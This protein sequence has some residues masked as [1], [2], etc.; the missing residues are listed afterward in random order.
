MG[1]GPSVLRELKK[2]VFV[3]QPL[4]DGS[5]RMREDPIFR[6]SFTNYIK[7][8]D[9]L[10]K[11]ATFNLGFQ[12]KLPNIVGKYSHAIYDYSV[13]AQL[14]SELKMH[15]ANAI[16][17]EQSSTM[18]GSMSQSQTISNASEKSG[19]RFTE[20]YFDIEDFSKFSREQLITIVFSILF[21]IYMASPA[22]QRFLTHGIERGRLLSAEE[23][24]ISNDVGDNSTRVGPSPLIKRAQDILLGCAAYFDECVIDRHLLAPEWTTT[25]IEALDGHPF[26]ITVTEA[27]TPPKHIVFANRAFIHQTGYTMAELSSASMDLFNGPDTEQPQLAMYRDAVNNNKAVKVGIV[28]YTKG[29]RHYVDLMAVRPVGCYSVAVHFVSTRSTNIDD[30]KV[31]THS[32]IISLGVFQLFSRIA[33]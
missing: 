12:I 18:S 32:S 24:I 29:H 19:V 1:H 7:S 2:S 4:L 33:E 16:V 26:G 17:F 30:L 28:R 20:S 21:P 13:S 25:L 31:N 22:Y 3:D 6:T 23:S 8:G 14:S 5:K 15:G 27:H 9:W 11:L 10:E